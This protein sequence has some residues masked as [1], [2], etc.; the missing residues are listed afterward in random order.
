MYYPFVRKA[1]FQL[2]PERAHEVTFQQLRRVTG[3]PLEMLVRQKV[4]ARPVTCMG[5]TFKNPLGLAAGL[6]KNGECIDALG[7]MGFGSIE[8]G[9]VTPRPQPGND[10]PRIFRL[11]DA[12][13]L[14]NRMGF[15]NHGVDNLV[16]NVKKAHFDGVLGI[17]IGKQNSSPLSGA[18]ADYQECMDKLYPLADYLAIDISCPN[19]PEL[20]KLQG[21]DE[22]GP[23]LKGIADKRKELADRTGRLVPITVKISPD[24][25][26]DAIRRAADQFVEY[27]MD[28][29][30]ATN[31]TL[32]RDNIKGLPN[33]D[34]VGGLS[35]RPLFERSTA[36]VRVLSDHL[37]G[38]LPIIA[39]G[40]VMTPEDAVA[41][42]EAGA[43]LVQLYTGFIYKMLGVPETL[44]TPLFAVARMA[45]W[46]A[47]RM[48]ELFCAHRIIRPAYRPVIE[49]LEYKPLADR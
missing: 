39:S 47:H 22:L 44:F 30:T 10:K 35:G 26:D 18:L 15:N 45:G 38:T 36:V 24:L 14:I 1:L 11:V 2:D 23:L 3:T 49:P 13:G 46:S 42:M 7:A 48:E 9:T 8:I 33:A 25:D 19:T 31:T 4:P 40:G 12:E 16:E 28:A 29:V 32:A 27:G 43:S 37:K 17:N 41:K 6:D 21:E 5:L 20:T 34:Q